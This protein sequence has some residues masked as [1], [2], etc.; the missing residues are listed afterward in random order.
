[1]QNNPN[2]IQSSAYFKSL[3]YATSF[4]LSQDEEKDFITTLSQLHN[5][6]L[7]IT[8]ALRQ[9]TLPLLYLTL[10]KIKVRDKITTLL[11]DQ[12]RPHYMHI[13]QNNM[14]K[15]AELLSLCSRFE[16]EGMQ[17]LPVKGPAL[18][19][20]AYHDITHRQFSDLDILVHR[21]DFRKI[22][23]ILME[24]SYTPHFPIADFQ[25]DKALFEM[26]NDCPFYR[27]EKGLSVEIHWD[28]F[29]K[30]ALPTE[31]FSPWTHTVKVPLNH[32]EISTLSHEMHLLYHA[33]HGSKHIWERLIWIVDIDRFIRSQTLDWEKIIVTAESLGA[34]KMFLLGP[35]LAHKYFSTP[36]PTEIHT[37]IQKAKLSSVM[38][39][40]DEEFQRD[41]PTPEESLVKFKL[42]LQLRDTPYFKIKMLL[43]FLFKPGINERR[44]IILPDSLFWLYWLIRP[45]GMGYRFIICRLFTF[46]K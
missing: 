44:T 46:C 39:F 32:A 10:R 15:T 13:V 8:Y 35:A 12:T 24:R 9:G 2:K 21:K 23:Q 28:F 17:V 45:V 18:A 6:Q 16:D 43:E 30:L 11:L 25:G 34:K 38:A 41:N 14:R 7:L 36:L 1:M 27:K 31:K 22:A 3:L 5:M 37:Q 19:M 29:R 42:L 26:N 4:E 20:I 33:L 40:I